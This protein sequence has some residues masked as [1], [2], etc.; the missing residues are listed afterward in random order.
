MGARSTGWRSEGGRDADGSRLDVTMEYRSPLCAM[1]FQQRSRSTSFVLIRESRGAFYG[2]SARRA[3]SGGEREAEA[4]SSRALRKPAS[5][6]VNKSRTQREAF[7]LQP[8]REIHKAT[9]VQ[10]N[11]HF[12]AELRRKV[13]RSCFSTPGW[14]ITLV[15]VPS[16]LFLYTRLF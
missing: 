4:E 9:S 3:G 13:S 8:V 12:A 15:P 16:A 2:S 6:L 11:S 7:E 14:S 1:S 10:L 5:F